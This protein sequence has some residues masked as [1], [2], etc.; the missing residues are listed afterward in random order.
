[1]NSK[2][3]YPKLFQMFSCYFNQDY[4]VMVENFDKSKLIVPQLVQGYKNES[5]S[6]SIKQ[7]MGEL[8]TL[9]KKKYDENVLDELFVELGNWIDVRAFGYTH[10]DF[11]IFILQELAGEEYVEYRIKEKPVKENPYV[12]AEGLKLLFPC[13]FGK[14]YQ[15]YTDIDERKGLVSQI[16]AS[17]KESVPEVEVEKSINELSNIIDKRYSEER[18]KNEI[19]PRFGF[20]LPVSVD[21]LGGAYQVF[22]EL[23]SEKLQAKN[24]DY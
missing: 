8:E 17:Y 22:L 7:V 13:Y 19:L 21:K 9:I 4:D 20:D 2:V 18:L 1:M 14:D 15:D 12:L 24:I 10:Q 6:N 11:L 5:S 16:V 23:L 3:I